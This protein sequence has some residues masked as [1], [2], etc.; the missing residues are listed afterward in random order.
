MNGAAFPSPTSEMVERNRI[1]MD[2]TELIIT[3]APEARDG[4]LTLGPQDVYSSAIMQ[5]PDRIVA[6]GDG[7]EAFPETKDLVLIQSPI[8][9]LSLK[10]P[11]K[12][13][14]LSDR[15]LDV[16]EDEQAAPDTDDTICPQESTSLEQD[17]AT[18]RRQLI[19]SN[20]RLKLIEE[21]NK[22]RTKREMIFYSITAAFCLV[23]TVVWLRR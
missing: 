10:T 12:V 3:V 18:L 2:Y 4:P 5:V 22:M 13:L 17:V 15:P 11:P 6:S 7:D 23:N 16:L 8:D 1:Q 20:Q 21:E 9:T 19:K 14:T